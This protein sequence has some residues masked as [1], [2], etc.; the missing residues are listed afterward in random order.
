MPALVG[1]FGNKSL[2]VFSLQSTLASCRFGLVV[3]NKKNYYKRSTPTPPALLAGVRN[4]APA[5]LYVPVRPHLSGVRNAAYAHDMRACAADSAS[6]V[7]RS[8]IRR[9]AQGVGVSTNASRCSSV[10]FVKVD[11]NLYKPR[12]GEAL[13]RYKF[14]RNYFTA[15]S[16]LSSSCV[17]CLPSCT[18]GEAGCSVRTHLWGVRQLKNFKSLKSCAKQIIFNNNLFPKPISAHAKYNFSSVRNL[19]ASAAGTGSAARAERGILNNYAVQPSNNLNPYYITGLSEAKSTFSIESN[20]SIEGFK[21]NTNWIA[22]VRF[23]IKLHSVELSLLNKLKTQ[24]GVGTISLN[25]EK[26]EAI[27]KVSKFKDIIDVIIPHFDK[28]PFQGVKSIDY[29]LWK[30]A[31]N[32]IKKKE[33]LTNEGLLKI[34]YIKTILS[35]GLDPMAKLDLFEISL[36]F[37]LGYKFA[38]HLDPNWITGFIERAGYFT[39]SIDDKNKVAVRLIIGS[40]IRELHLIK[41]IFEYFNTGK[42]NTTEKVV[43]FTM[44]NIADIQLKVIPHFDKYL[45]QGNKYK[46][47]LIWKEILIKVCNK[48]HLTKEGLSKII[49]LRNKLN[50]QDSEI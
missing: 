35:F 36:G 2:R 38:S 4:A 15:R 18:A 28:Y 46:N 5:N 17:P 6:S 10:R 9:Q 48:E 19:T 32:F 13:M 11:K 31:V 30:E 50:I 23:L 12:A 1:G 25:T 29:D 26:N 22:S 34:L 40:H 33:H 41:K 24:L 7:G 47:Y 21:D 37:K 49:K 43:N 16:A 8:L 42:I 39:V 44:G 3:I 45:L 27:F 14:I 20:Y